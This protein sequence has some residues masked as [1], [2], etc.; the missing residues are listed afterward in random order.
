MP[1]PPA[2]SPATIRTAVTVVRA[3]TLWWQILVEFARN[4]GTPTTRMQ[5]GPRR[6]ARLSVGPGAWLSSWW[7]AT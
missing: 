4:P 6:D 3:E 5:R 2:H 7:H 1:D